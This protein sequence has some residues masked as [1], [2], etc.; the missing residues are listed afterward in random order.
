MNAV[1]KRISFAE[2]NYVTAT[3]YAT[4]KVIPE[5]IATSRLIDT[6]KS[7][8]KKINTVKITAID[9]PASK[10]RAK[11]S[12]AREICLCLPDSFEPGEYVLKTRDDVSSSFKDEN[13]IV[14]EGVSGNITLQPTVGENNVAG[15]FDIN[16][17]LPDTEGETFILKG[18]FQVLKAG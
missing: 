10:T 7:G 2:G 18:K 6:V 17:E 11:S 4:H 15:L 3:P 8:P 5:F 1:I 12:P 14:Y 13:G 16:Y 9:R